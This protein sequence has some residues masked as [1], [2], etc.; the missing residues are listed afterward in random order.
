MML[1]DERLGA[2]VLCFIAP[3]LNTHLFPPDAW[4]PT[5]GFDKQIVHEDEHNTALV[6]K[7]QYL[8]LFLWGTWPFHMA[9]LELHKQN[10][11]KKNN[12][13]TDAS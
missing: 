10:S 12:K 5:G 2:P 6:P 3:H 13:L 1:G 11:H 4:G 8:P 7:W 9:C